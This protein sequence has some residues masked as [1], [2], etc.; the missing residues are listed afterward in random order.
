[1]HKAVKRDHMRPAHPLDAVHLHRLV[2]DMLTHMKT[3][4]ERTV[5]RQPLRMKTAGTN[6]PAFAAFHGR[7]LSG[8]P[9]LGYVNTLYMLGKV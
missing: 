1:M 9:R 8:A 7:T 3:Q 6:V 5:N 4:T 2:P